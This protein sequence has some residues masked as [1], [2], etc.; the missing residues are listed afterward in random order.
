MSDYLEPK[1]PIEIKDY[2]MNWA[3]VLAAENETTIATSTWAVSPSGLTL[4]SSPAPAISGSITS[5][6]VSGG[7][8]GTV[9]KLSNTIVTGSGTPRTHHGSSLIACVEA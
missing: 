5:V 4:L 2:G 8:V 1:D 6:W 3:T 7:T 9:Y